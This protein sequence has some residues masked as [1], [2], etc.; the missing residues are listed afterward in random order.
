MCTAAFLL[1]G[2][3]MLCACAC[4]WQCLC[5]SASIKAP[6]YTVEHYSDS[7]AGN[8]QCEVQLVNALSATK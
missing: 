4:D 2:A 1:I 6:K 5:Q 7:A 8:D 3:T